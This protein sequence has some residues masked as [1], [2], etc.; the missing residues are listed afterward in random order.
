MGKFGY[1]DD[2][3][4]DCLVST[5]ERELSRDISRKTL[6]HFQHEIVQLR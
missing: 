5:I 2:C 3:W 6:I 4:A 1:N